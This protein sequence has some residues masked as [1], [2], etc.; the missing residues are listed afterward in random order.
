MNTEID[1]AYI[2]RLK[3]E[4]AD[5]APSTASSHL[6]EGI[7]AGFGFNTNAALM[8]ALKQ[9]QIQAT[10]D[11][12]AA[13]QRLAAIGA[14]PCPP[15]G[16]LRLAAMRL[17]VKAAMD[18]MPALTVF[19]FGVFSPRSKTPDQIESE[20][21]K[22]RA[23]MLEPD[24]LEQFD[25]CYQWMTRLEKTKSIN[26]DVSSYGLKHK[27]ESHW[28]AVVPSS[29]SY[30]AN[31]MLIAS[32]HAAGFKVVR[33]GDSPNAM[34][35]VSV[36]SIKANSPNKPLLDGTWTVE[37]SD[38]RMLRAP[39]STQ[40]PAKYQRVDCPSEEEAITLSLSLVAQN[41]FY[42]TVQRGREPVY[43]LAELQAIRYWQRKSAQQESSPVDS[44]A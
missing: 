26:A 28:R 30:V 44:P 6:T 25:R 7:A 31:G 20:S 17:L 15:Q 36:R 5:L 13:W 1:L 3:R 42:V 2:K 24:A 33:V 27:V 23:E 40:P 9:G 38:H 4:F 22:L 43:E 34:F 32:A 41:K 14:D 16:T 19:G 39:H 11:D 37:W 35:N 29:H 21:A 10:L 12:T 18:A 8:A